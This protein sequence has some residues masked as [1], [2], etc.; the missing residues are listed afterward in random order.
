[1]II[2]MWSTLFVSRNVVMAVSSPTHPAHRGW[3]MRKLDLSKLEATL[4]ADAAAMVPPPGGSDQSA[5]E[6]VQ[7]LK[8][9]LEFI[10]DQV[11]PRRGRPSPEWSVFWW[12]EEIAEH[13][14]VC[15]SSL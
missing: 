14:R 6:V 11:M 3:A 2:G 5:E 15:V 10:S 12:S 7:A 4:K 1:M 13:R 9:Y 8:T